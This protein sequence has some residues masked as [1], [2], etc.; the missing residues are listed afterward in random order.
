MED[1]GVGIRVALYRMEWIWMDWVKGRGGVGWVRGGVEWNG[2]EWSFGRG[3]IS[4]M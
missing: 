1:G 4:R 2:V 3:R